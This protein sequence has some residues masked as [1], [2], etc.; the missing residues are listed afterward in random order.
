[1]QL[2]SREQELEQ[3]KIEI[4]QIRNKRA[5]LGNIKKKWISFLQIRYKEYR[6]IRI[7]RI[8]FLIAQLKNQSNL[9]S[10]GGSL[11]H[12]NSF[13]KDS[14]EGNNKSKNMASSVEELNDI[15]DD[16]EEE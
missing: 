8:F 7:L 6:I 16:E 2:Q 13:H 9:S 11:F 1:M 15:P 10:G 3:L 4:Q 12:A 5:N 14:L